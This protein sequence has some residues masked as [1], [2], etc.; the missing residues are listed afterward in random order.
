MSKP[1]P[2]P[3]RHHYRVWIKALIKSGFIEKLPPSYDFDPSESPRGTEEYARQLM[4]ELRDPT[5]SRRPLQEIIADARQFKT[6][7]EARRRDSL[8]RAL[9]ES[10][11]EDR[12]IEMPPGRPRAAIERDQRPQRPRTE[13][14]SQPDVSPELHPMW[15]DWIDRLER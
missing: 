5:A 12:I 9:V 8:R 15:D 4:T 11:P 10:R 2:S 14:T 7:V 6:W 1:E 3:N 13:R